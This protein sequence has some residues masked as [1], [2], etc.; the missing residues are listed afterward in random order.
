MMALGVFPVMRL[1]DELAAYFNSP[2]MWIG[3]KLLKSY[4]SWPDLWFGRGFYSVRYTFELCGKRTV[5]QA[6]ESPPTNS[7]RCF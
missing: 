3:F 2:I 5:I 6:R 1:A 7:L 4:G